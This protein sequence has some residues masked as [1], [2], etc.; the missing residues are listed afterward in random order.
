[1]LRF[2]LPKF[3]LKVFW[4][5]VLFLKQLEV[6][7]YI[8]V[9]VLLITFERMFKNV[10]AKLYLLCLRKQQLV[11]TISQNWISAHTASFLFIHEL[12]APLFF[13]F[14]QLFLHGAY[15]LLCLF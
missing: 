14:V 9:Y 4:T 10:N 15:N 7:L 8:P 3:S 13:F 1:M 11:R 6:V 12:L 2:N 5:R